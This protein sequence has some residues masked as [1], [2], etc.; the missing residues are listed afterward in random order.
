MD[1]YLESRWPEVHA[2]LIVYASNQINDQLPDD[3][4]ANIEESV[5][6]SADDERERTIRPDVHHS[7]DA[8]FPTNTG[9]LST[10]TVARPLLIR[11]VPHPARHIEIVHRDGRVI[12][13]I[14]FVSPWNKVG[15][16]GRQQYLRKQLDYLDA[17]I[18]LVEVDLV[19]QGAYVLAAPLD[20][21]PPQQRT[22]CLICVY[23]VTQP[24]LFELYL[25]PL[26][27]VLPNVPVPLRPHEDDIV[28]QL[29]PLIDDCYRD[30]RYH[31]TDYQHDPETP[32]DA[33]DTAWMDARLRDQGRRE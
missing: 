5:S 19:R 7:E 32:F 33:A 1:P 13:A 23:R 18:N 14:E 27:E 11:R 31:R 21:V 16:R 2:R 4:R 24:D 22:P 9:N 26:Q 12:T 6:V 20:D 3:L 10:A 15:L 25:A 17:G 30:G 8:L 28:L 29:Q